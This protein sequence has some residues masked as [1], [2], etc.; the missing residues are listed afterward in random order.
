[1]PTRPEPQSMKM[2][3]PFAGR[4]VGVGCSRREGPTPEGRS[5]L[6]PPPEGIFT[7]AIHAGVV[8]ATEHENGHHEE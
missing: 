6:S 5:L 8:G 4:G 2:G 3:F 1:M 7:G